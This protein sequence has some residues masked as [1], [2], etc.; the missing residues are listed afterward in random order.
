MLNN[1]QIAEYLVRGKILGSGGEYIVGTGVI[2]RYTKA[3]IYD[4]TIIGAQSSKW[5]SVDPSSIEKCIG[6]VDKVGTPIFNNDV[7]VDDRTGLKTVVKYDH[8]DKTWTL[9][10]SIN[11][12]EIAGDAR[13]LDT[14]A[15]KLLVV[16][17][18]ENGFLVDVV[19]YNKPIRLEAYNDAN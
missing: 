12:V 4:E 10:H 14:I 15:D 18:Y 6:V 17:H 1:A 3:S 13:F 16:G 8:Y 7:L 2:I 5:V 11:N 19:K 9:T